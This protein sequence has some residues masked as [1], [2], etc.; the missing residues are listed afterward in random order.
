MRVTQLRLAESYFRKGGLRAKFKFMGIY[1]PSETIMGPFEVHV[2]SAYLEIRVNHN[3][4]LWQHF[5]TGAR[6]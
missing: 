3:F 1:D 6:Q 4:C 2:Y 5:L